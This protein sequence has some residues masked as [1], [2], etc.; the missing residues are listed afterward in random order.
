MV[1]TQPENVQHSSPLLFCIP[2]WFSHNGAD[3]PTKQENAQ[4]GFKNK[5]STNI[6]IGMTLH[7]ACSTLAHTCLCLPELWYQLQTL[8]GPGCSPVSAPPGE[9]PWPASGAPSDSGS[10][11]RCG[12]SS[13]SAPRASLC[14]VHRPAVSPA[15]QNSR[16]VWLHTHY[17]RPRFLYEQAVSE[18]LPYV[19]IMSVYV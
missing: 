12:P 16:T 1:P 19:S 14:I 8:S 15:E 2:L 3:T 18:L 13:H 7:T 6:C 5:N 4:N 9:Q 10:L 11:A 17:E